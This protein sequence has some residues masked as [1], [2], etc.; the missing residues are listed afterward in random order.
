MGRRGSDF[1]GGASD[2]RKNMGNNEKYKNRKVDKAWKKQT[3]NKQERA[4]VGGGGIVSSVVVV[5]LVF[6]VW[7]AIFALIYWAAQS[8]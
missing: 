6:G 3:R 7:I 5:G 8:D 2:W 4:D 1:R